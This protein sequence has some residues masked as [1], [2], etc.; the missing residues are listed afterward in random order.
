MNRKK[1]HIII[2]G[3]AIMHIL[4]C[5]LCRMIGI[6]D[7]LILTLATMAMVTILCIEE[8]LSTEFTAITIVLANILG[9][10]LGTQ[11]AQLLGINWLSTFITTE[12]LG[13]GTL[14]MIHLLKPVRAERETFWK[15]N[16]GW[17]VAAVVIVFSLRVAID[18]I[19]S[20]TRFGDSPSIAIIAEV[21]S[22]CLLL[23]TF[24]MLYMR[25]QVEREREKNRSLQQTLRLYKAESTEY[26]E[27]YLVHLNNRIVPIHVKDVAYFYAKNKST[28]L[29][30]AEGANPPVDESLDTLESQLDPR[31]FFRISRGCIIASSAIRSVAKIQGGRLV[32][33]PAQSLPALTELTVSRARVQAFLEWFEG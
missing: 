31:L 13:W 18:L 29:V 30:T 25:N 16:V 9:F 15:E 23:L 32:I 6:P 24:F 21:S 17:L 26:R 1:A 8:Y 27:K 12:L 5:I 28:Y 11:G 33:S 3:F 2:H 14:L 7:T 20:H 10:I 4:L 22:F 19:I